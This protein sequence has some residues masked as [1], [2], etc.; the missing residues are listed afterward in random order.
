MHHAGDAALVLGLDGDD[1]A[2]AADGDEFLL[3]GA[4]FRQPAHLGA[5]RFLDDALLFFNLAAQ[6]RQFG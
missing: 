4:A 6:A 5:Q 2:L 3:G 1:E